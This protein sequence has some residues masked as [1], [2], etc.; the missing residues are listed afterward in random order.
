M[1][2]VVG[3]KRD[4]TERFASKRK[5]GRYLWKFY[6]YLPAFFVWGNGR[7]VRKMLSGEFGHIA[8]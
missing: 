4:E 3:K 2:G 5:A 1:P 6:K 7:T 8:Y